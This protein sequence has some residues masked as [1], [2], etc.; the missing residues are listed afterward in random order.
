[1][2]KTPQVNFKIVNNNVESSV[3]LLGVTHVV[4][5]TTKGP[6]NDPSTLITGIEQFRR[7][8]GEEVIDPTS[9]SVSTI[10]KALSLGSKL[11]ISRVE[12]VS[13][14]TKGTATNPLV[15]KLKNSTEVTQ[16]SL[17]LETLYGGYIFDDSQV[18]GSL[19]LTQKTVEKAG[20]T[21]ITLE[22][23][24]GENTL[25][26]DT[27][28]GGGEDWL[29]WTTF[30]D[31]LQTAAFAVKTVSVE[32][33]LKESIKTLDA[34]IT[35]MSTSEGVGLDNSTAEVST[36]LSQGSNGGDN[37]SS[38]MYIKA[39]K[40]TQDYVD[41]YQVILPQACHYTFKKLSGTSSEVQVDSTGYNTALKGIADLVVAAQEEVLYVE[42]PVLNEDG[43]V[44]YDLTTDAGIKAFQTAITNIQGTVGTSPYIAY[45]TGGL[46]YYNAQGNLVDSDIIG[47]V[48]G[49]GDAS[50][51]NYGP[52]KSF[53][54]MNRGVVNDAYGPVI[55]N[56]GTPSKISVLQDIADYSVNL[57]VVKDTQSQGK[58]TMLWHGFTSNPKSDSERFLSIVRLNL[59]IKKNLR[60]I[61]ESY[62]EEPNIW[63][64]WQNIYFQGK[65]IMDNLVS[66]SAISEYTWMGDQDASSYDD[67][68][69]NTE[70]EVRQG[71]YKLII[72]YKDIVPIQD[73]Q[74]TLTIDKASGT[75]TS[76]VSA[77]N[78]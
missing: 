61:L 28:L 66:D 56:L 29:D 13:G 57:F 64:T 60:P 58:R 36:T 42:I 19:D 67:L 51:S 11:R 31:Y 59:Y 34:L 1:M 50:A 75:V 17:T 71:K 41:A 30:R 49:L 16:F 48:A 10:E 38:D 72:K 69:V 27:I 73:I 21:Y 63:D 74:V 55:A 37:P 52:W 43:E 35:W 46:K 77:T 12:G 4:A 68:V 40:A 54:G 53:A 2:P 26:T 20:K 14:Q 25:G 44:A 47:T 23:K 15:V 45:F 78:V 5:R 33:T 18:M 70:A 65:P 8:F 32:G 6:F 39:F 24:V 62:L 9:S 3:P 76:E 22:S 7:L